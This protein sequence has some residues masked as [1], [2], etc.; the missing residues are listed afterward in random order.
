[1][2]L[3]FE[4]HDGHAATVEE[5]VACFADATDNDLTQF[6]RWYRQAGTPEVVVQANH[7]AGAKTCT[8]EIA[9][10][11]PP[12]PGQPVKEPMVIPL[13]IGL[14]GPDGRDRAGDARADGPTLERGVLTLTQ[15]KQTFVFTGLDERP[16]VSL[17][18]GF[19]APGQADRQPARRR[20]RLPRR[21]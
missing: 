16:V 7:D 8:L 17:N 18:R 11:L 13:A 9:Q 3:Y 21:P 1:M 10:M 4:R 19:S 20:S 5:F 6:M 15:A 2:D 12:T 14:L